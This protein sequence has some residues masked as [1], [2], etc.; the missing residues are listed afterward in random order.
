MCAR[1][2]IIGFLARG[3]PTGMTTFGNFQMCECARPA[4]LYIIKTIYAVYRVRAE[5]G[6]RGGF[7]LQRT[8][9]II[10]IIILCIYRSRAKHGNKPTHTAC[11]CVCVCSCRH[12]SDD[13]AKSRRHGRLCCLWPV[14]ADII[15][16]NILFMYVFHGYQ[17]RR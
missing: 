2:S 17:N 1:Q 15:I 7:P 13:G 6:V 10:I 14:T 5:G 4:K 12:E 3:S 11:V 9:Y 16:Y 8:V